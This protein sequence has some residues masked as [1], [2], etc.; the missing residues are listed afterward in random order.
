MVKNT[1]IVLLIILFG[2]GI[3]HRFADSP[4]TREIKLG[5]SLPLSG[6]NQNLGNEIVTG[7]N[8]YFSFINS[9][10]GING[11]LIKFIY[12]DDKYEPEITRVNI[13][14]LIM[15]DKVFALFD[16]VGTPTVKRVFPTII[17]SDI[18]F[19]APY[20]GA[21]FLRNNDLPNIVNLRSSY[22]EE[23]GA[24]VNYL[25][26]KKNISRISIFYQNDEYGQEGYI[27]L[28]KA[29]D[30][31]GLPLISEGTYKRNT[32][33]VKQAIHD[34]HSPKPEAIILVGAYKPTARF[35][36]KARASKDLKN[37]LFCPISFVNSDALIQELNG[38]GKNIIFSQTVPPYTQPSK[39]AKEYKKLLKRYTPGKR[40]SFASFESFLAAKAVVKAIKASRSRIDRKNFLYHLKHPHDNALG[41]IKMHYKNTQLLNKVYLLNYRNGKFKVIGEKQ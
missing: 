31:V 21:K 18:P 34:I 10:N 39:N 37:V 27:A 29:L 30:H 9:H 17:K 5:A 26:N 11:K 13:E 2:I 4:E 20:T 24:L 23:I 36:Q 12:Y 41:D 14:Q 25:V 19:I 35:I 7:A 32:L 1:F 22:Q 38:D 3:I 15:N 8:I 33:F 28:L 40:P 6:I 16:F